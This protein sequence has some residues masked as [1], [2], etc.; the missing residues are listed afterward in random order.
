VAQTINLNHQYPDGLVLY[1][2]TMFAPVE[3]RDTPGQGFTHKVGDRVRVS[4]PRLGVLEN[5]VATCDQAPPW[6]FGV[7]ALMQNL[8]ARGLLGGA[9]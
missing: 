2:G 3:D 7:G 8:A 6:T 1:L 4:S 5:R 9:T